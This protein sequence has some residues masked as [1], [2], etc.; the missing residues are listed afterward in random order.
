M[1]KGWVAQIMPE[2]NTLGQ[3]FI[4]SQNAR[5]RTPDLRDFKAMRQSRAVII[6]FMGD[7]NL[8]LTFET[9]KSRTVNNAV[10]VA[11]KRAA[12]AARRLRNAPAAC[13]GRV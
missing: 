3:I 10:F 8:S 2:A 7:K 1:T 6:T 13:A 9:A 11:L 12:L 4:K 5:Y